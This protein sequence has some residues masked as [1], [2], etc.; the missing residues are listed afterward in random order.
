MKR[1]RLFWLYPLIYLGILI[2]AIKG[3]KNNEESVA[4]TNTVVN[5]DTSVFIGPQSW[6]LDENKIIKYNEVTLIPNDTTN[7]RWLNFTTR[8]DW[9][10]RFYDGSNLLIY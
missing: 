9:R 4:L 5:T 2:Y 10:F 6:R 7:I 1:D 8:I 3:E